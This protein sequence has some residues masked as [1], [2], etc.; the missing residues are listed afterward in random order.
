MWGY[1]TVR[2]NTCEATASFNMYNSQ[3]SLV[4][5]HTICTIGHLWY[6][7]NFSLTT[8]IYIRFCIRLLINIQYEISLKWRYWHVSAYTVLYGSNSFTRISRTHQY[9]HNSENISPCRILR[10]FWSFSTLISMVFHYGRNPE[11]FT[12]VVF[13]Q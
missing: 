3:W 9:S 13:L 5:Y 8:A 10:L 6:I 11:Y 7:S 2:F 4:M 12:N 1:F